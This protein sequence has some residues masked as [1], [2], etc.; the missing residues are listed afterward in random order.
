MIK[1]STYRMVTFDS[2][3]LEPVVR[4][5]LFRPF[6]EYAEEKGFS[7]DEPLAALSVTREEAFNP[8]TFVHAEAVY[9]FLNTLAD[10]VGDPHLG[11]HV[12]ESTDIREWPPLATAF[13]N[14]GSLGDF[15]GAWIRSVPQ[16]ATT[17][18]YELVQRVGEALLRAKRP[19]Q[20]LNSPRQ[21]DGF[22]IA[23]F[24]RV[25]DFVQGIEVQPGDV[26]VRTMYPEAFP[27][28]YRGAYV[29]R[30]DDYA[31]VVSF[32]SE[33]L[34]ARIVLKPEAANTLGDQASASKAGVS[35]VHAVRTSVERL[36]PRGCVTVEN[37]AN[38]VGLEPRKLKY[39]LSKVETSVSQ[40]L[41]EVRLTLAKEALAKTDT[42]IAD[43]AT[44]LGFSD[45][46][47]FSRF[48]RAQTGMTP[49][50]FRRN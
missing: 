44:W 22:G 9:C 20:P 46:A 30:S 10:L 5:S 11:C 33:W 24:L 29:G 27:S 34:P 50:E 45:P 16:H 25:F 6:I 4:L 47:H 43:L 14:G 23:M 32:P 37:V 12:G 18:R 7:L 17:V 38:A 19:R 40:E 3:S 42:S 21:T 49:S 48:F 35:L 13:E 39:A 41:R 31:A 26:R 15:F 36:L 2:S 1:D 8:A 28:A